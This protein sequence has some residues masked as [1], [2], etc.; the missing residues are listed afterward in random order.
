MRVV[1]QM[2]CLFLAMTS[3]GLLAMSDDLL[4]GDRVPAFWDGLIAPGLTY[5]EYIG[6]EQNECDAW[7]FPNEE[8]ERFV[9]CLA[10]E[11]R[12]GQL[13]DELTGRHVLRAGGLLIAR[14]ALGAIQFGTRSLSSTASLLRT[15]WKVLK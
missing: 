11:V 15:L 6:S 12:A 3:G 7:L 8:R 4:I 13:R 1:L 14:A 10:Q 9:M 5:E 2:S